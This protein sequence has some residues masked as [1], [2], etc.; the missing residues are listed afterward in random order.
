MFGAKITEYLEK[1]GVVPSLERLS[2]G[3][4]FVN[5]APANCNV[6]FHFPVMTKGYFVA[7]L[8]RKTRD[9]LFQL[10]IMKGGYQKSSDG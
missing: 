7:L 5:L 2:N 6:V 10:P 1:P 8:D 3:I 4:A 9:K